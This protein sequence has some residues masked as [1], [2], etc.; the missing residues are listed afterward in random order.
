MTF[1]R[2]AHDISLFASPIQRE[3]RIEAN[4]PKEGET[5]WFKH[6]A[7]NI[8]ARRW[9]FGVAEQ[10]EVPTELRQWVGNGN[11]KSLLSSK[12]DM[13]NAEV[14]EGEENNDRPTHRKHDIAS[15]NIFQRTISRAQAKGMKVNN[16]KTQ[17]L[18]VSGA[19]S[20]DPVAFIETGD[21][22]VLES[23][24]EKIKILGFYLDGT[25]TVSAQV[26]EIVRKVRHRLWV[27][28]H[29]KSYGFNS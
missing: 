20:Y 24:R 4:K 12:I 14:E 9:D 19:R 26:E 25:P 7:R 15:Q 2:R 29:L 3:E 10:K 16:N 1:Q 13:V 5:F 18:L 8:C 17:M 11:R 21:G 28:R 6:T 27:L 23:S 22:N